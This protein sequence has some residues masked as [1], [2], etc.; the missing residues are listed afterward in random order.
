MFDCTNES[1]RERIK[2]LRT[3][4]KVRQEELADYLNIKRTTYQSHEAKGN[5]SW[6][7][8]ELIADFFDKSPY[9]LKYGV[10]DSELAEIVHR[11]TSI[12]RS[13][14]SDNRFTIFDDLEEQLTY[15]KRFTDFVCLDKDEQQRIIQY[16][17]NKN[18]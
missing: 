18:L 9:F 3:I 10:E 12:K 6:E 4:R 8:L 5:F 13:A 17:E 15:L 11:A 16:I 2:D 1:I 14:L 7:E